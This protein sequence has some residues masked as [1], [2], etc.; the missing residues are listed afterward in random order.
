M[1]EEMHYRYALK[2]ALGE[3]EIGDVPVMFREGARYLVGEA[4][5]DLLTWDKA[6]RWSEI[7]EIR[8]EKETAG[9]PFK[10]SVLDSDERSVTKLNTAVATAQ[11][12]GESFTIDWTMQD[13]SVMT[14]VYADLLSIPAALATYSNELHQK[15]REMKTQI[16]ACETVKGVEAVVWE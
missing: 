14:L 12:I 9:C 6:K 3:L 2:V 11:S 5:S 8:N 16:D 4:Y 15:A 7:K 10:G 1:Y 13:N